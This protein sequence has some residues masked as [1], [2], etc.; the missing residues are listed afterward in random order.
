VKKTLQSALFA[1]TVLLYLSIPQAETQAKR[2]YS[3]AEIYRLTLQARRVY[4]YKKIK[5]NKQLNAKKAYHRKLKHA[6]YKGKCKTVGLHLPGLRRCK[7]RCIRFMGR[8]LCSPQMNCRTFRV[9]RKTVKVCPVC[10]VGMRYV[11]T[12]VCVKKSRGLYTLYINGRKEHITSTIGRASQSTYDGLKRA[13]AALDNGVKKLGQD[14]QRTHRRVAHQATTEFHKNLKKFE[15]TAQARINALVRGNEYKKLFEG[16]IKMMMATRGAKVIALFLNKNYKSLVKILK[17]KNYSQIQN[18]MRAQKTGV[19]L[20]LHYGKAIAITVAL[21]TAAHAGQVVLACWR[22]SGN[23]KRRCLKRQMSYAYQRGTYDIMA[24]TILAV[25]DIKIFEPL[26]HKIAATVTA[27]LASSTLGIGA[28]AYPIVYGLTSATLNIS[29][30][31]L[32]QHVIRRQWDNLY[33]SNF[34]RSVDSRN[35]R[36]VNSLSSDKMRCYSSCQ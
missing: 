17:N 25:I 7:Q 12:Q 2:K 31:A 30:S 10:S 1:L 19:K 21:T 13:L 36:W 23:S 18:T 11:K 3:K 6:L 28:A 24:G 14:I 5:S 26:S 27:A 32:S 8:R 9:F 15:K 29:Y 33:R 34:K 16:Q 35:N 22:Q 20:A 4:V